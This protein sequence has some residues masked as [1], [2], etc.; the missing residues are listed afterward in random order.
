MT[1]GLVLIA[2]GGGIGSA[3]RFLTSV[4][5]AHWLGPEFPYGTL[6]VNLSGAFILGV[7]QELALDR[8][9]ADSLPGNKSGYGLSAFSGISRIAWFAICH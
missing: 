5:A 1:E 8:R 7:V 3:L 2:V 6:I 4:A 9:L